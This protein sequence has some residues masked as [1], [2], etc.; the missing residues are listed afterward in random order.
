MRIA[1]LSGKGGTG[2][3]LLSVNLAS[4][5]MDSSYIDCDVEEPNGHLFFKPENVKA[6]DISV[7]I[8]VIDRNICD[9]CRRCVDFCMFN[10]LAYTGGNVI[11]F[12]GICHSC[13]GCAIVCPQNAI[14]EK[15]RPIGRIEKGVSGSVCVSTGILNTGE[16]SGIPIIKKMLEDSGKEAESYTFIDCPPGSACIVMESIKDADYC[17]L[18]AEPTIFGAHNLNLVYELVRLFD[19]P[20]GVVLN[21]CLEGE[22]NPSEELCK[23]NNMKILARIPFDYELGTINSNARIAARENEK[24]RSLFQS[25]LHAVSKEVSS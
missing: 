20:H 6:E 8:P 1:V 12:D 9:G 25:I 18:V 24:Y 7:R 10:A 4:V 21:K 15:D 22:E 2:K 11:L 14:S 16:S 17:L 5:A 13:G 3:T 19:K 23:R